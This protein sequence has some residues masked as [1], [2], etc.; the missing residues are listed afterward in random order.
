MLRLNAMWTEIDYATEIHF[1]LLK[2]YII[3]MIQY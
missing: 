3:N 1:E 2:D